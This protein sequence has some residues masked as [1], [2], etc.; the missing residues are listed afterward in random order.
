MTAEKLQKVSTTVV[1][2]HFR[3]RW[4]KWWNS[5]EMSREALH[6]PPPGFTDATL[7]SWLPRAAFWAEVTDVLP[8][9]LHMLFS[10][11]D[12]LFLCFCSPDAYPL[13]CIC[14][15]TAGRLGVNG[16]SERIGVRQHTH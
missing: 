16:S 14:L 13:N 4:L 15:Y 10:L 2:P 5:S 6:F 7:E 9:L 12:V 8:Q 3:V 1:Q 11:Y